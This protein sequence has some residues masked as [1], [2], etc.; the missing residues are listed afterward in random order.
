MT[1]LSDE[2]VVRLVRGG[3]GSAPGGS[4][5]ADLWP[6]VRERIERGAPPPTISDWLLTLAV[7]AL[8]LIQPAAFGI[9]LLHL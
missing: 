1:P 6:R 8:C 3:L 4:T 2:D 7:V 9:L 5:D